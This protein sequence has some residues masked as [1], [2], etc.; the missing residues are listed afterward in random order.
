MAATISAI[1]RTSTSTVNRI[2]LLASSGSRFY[3]TILTMTLGIEVETRESFQ[4]ISTLLALLSSDSSVRINESESA[5]QRDIYLASTCTENAPPSPFQILRLV[6][7]YHKRDDR[8][9][10]RLIIAYV[11]L[12]T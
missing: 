12:F 11:I 5:R 1:S 7:I 3:D 6:A 2:D 4:L 10:M 9:M 8:I